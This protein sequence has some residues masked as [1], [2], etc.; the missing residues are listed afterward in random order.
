MESLRVVITGLRFKTDLSFVYIL[1]R[2][3]VIFIHQ[4]L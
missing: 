1:R 3:S 2:I 4:N